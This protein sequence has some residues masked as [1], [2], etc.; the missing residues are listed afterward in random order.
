MI[1]S[2]L[3]KK[4]NVRLIFEQK[5]VP[6]FQN[7][8]FKTKNEAITCQ[9][10][11]VKLYQC[12]DTGFVFSGE[13][14][15]G[16]LDYN[17]DYQNEQGNSNYFQEHLNHVYTLMVERNL[18][19]GKIV[20]IGC[21]KGLFLDL[22]KAKGHRVIG[23]DP[24]YEGDSIDVIKEYYSEKHK[25]LKADFIVLRHTLEHIASPYDFLEMIAKANSPE[26]MIYIE[27]PTF[28]WIYKHEAVEDVFYEHCNYFTAKSFKSLFTDCEIIPV[29]NAQY[30]G[31]F[32]KLGNLK[33]RNEIK[34][35]SIEDFSNIFQKAI[36][37]YTG[38][39]NSDTKKMIWGA[40]AKGSTFLNI[41]DPNCSHID[42][43]IDIN[44]KKQNRY[45][46]GTGHLIVSPEILLSTQIDEIIVVNP[47]YL[48][49]IDATIKKMGLSIQ[50][51]T[52]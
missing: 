41:M 4:E 50:L 17:E 37:N 27:I 45:I 30:M 15:A 2:P 36:S 11:P 16:I 29:F 32:A 40:G 42:A 10:L 26:T 18:V 21:G 22:L 33:K 28:E 38:L 13:F 46:G 8:V 31:I 39:V 20:E 7:K 1:V 12:L 6:V 25:D 23:V 52:L 51:K 5:A 14:N 48:K 34:E 9:K 3:T 35:A 43:V 24:T 49:E 44:P 47:N 19:H